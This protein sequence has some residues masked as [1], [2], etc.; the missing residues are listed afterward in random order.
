[1]KLEAAIS[2]IQTKYLIHRSPET[3]ADL[4]AGSG[5]FTQALSTLLADQS[6]IYAI[7]KN[8]SPFDL[9]TFRDRVF[10]R[11]QRQDFEMDTMDLLNLDGI[12]MA[13][14]LHFIKNKP[15]FLERAKT[16]FRNKPVFL[17]VEYDRDDSNPWVPYPLSFHSLKE[18]FTRLAFSDIEKIH[19]VKSLYGRGKMYSAL[20]R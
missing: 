18:L 20:I 11:Q 1:M 13:N 19:E 14:S 2:L 10:I 8:L 6:V 3:W 9:N 15:A 4:G 17:V 7:D 5:L 12:L 16:W